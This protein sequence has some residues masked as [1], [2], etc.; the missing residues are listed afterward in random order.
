MMRLIYALIW[1]NLLGHY[2]VEKMTLNLMKHYDFFVER[3]QQFRFEVS[4][5]I[6]IDLI[7][8]I[9]NMN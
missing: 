7:R 5:L 8:D 3:G 9:L 2:E 6:F 1:K 4:N